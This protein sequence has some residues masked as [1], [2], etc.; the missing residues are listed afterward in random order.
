MIPIKLSLKNFMCYREAELNLEGIHLACLNGDNG[1]G[2]SSLLDAI[3]WSLWGKSRASDDEIITQQEVEMAVHL[4]FSMGEQTY[5]VS[6]LRSKKG[7]GKTELNFSIYNGSSWTRISED[8]VRATQTKI[9]KTLGMSYETF[10]NS[11]FLLQGHA[12]EFTVRT[13]TERK[14]VLAEILGLGYYDELEQRAKEFAKDAE[15][16]RRDLAHQLENLIAI[17]QQRPLFEL[18]FKEAENELSSHIEKLKIAED[19]KSRLDITKGALEAKEQRKRDLENRLKII[20]KDVA[21][22]N[23]KRTEAERAKQSCEVIIQN[24]VETEK[25]Y[26]QFEKIKSEDEILQ[27]KASRHLELS[28]LQVRLSGA[29][30]NEKR[31]LQMK[32]NAKQES[33]KEQEKLAFEV[34]TIRHELEKAQREVEKANEAASNLEQYQKQQN[35]LN[36][37]QG[38]FAGEIKRLNDEMKRVKAKADQLPAAGNPCERCGALMTEEARECT[39]Q[40]YRNE[41]AELLQQQKQIKLEKETIET[42]LAKLVD[43]IAAVEPLAKTRVT[44]EKRVASV[45]VKLQNAEQA[46]Q[47]IAELQAQIDEFNRQ[48]ENKEYAQVEQQKLAQVEAELVVLNYDDKYHQKIQVQRDELKHF[49]MEYNQRLVPTLDRLPL[50][51]EQL[52]DFDY[53]LNQYQTEKS[54]KTNNLGELEAELSGLEELRRK[55]SRVT[56]EVSDIRKLRDSAQQRKAKAEFNLEE[57]DAAASEREKVQKLAEQANL[58]K[59]LYDD[60]AGAFGKKGIQALVIESVLPELEAE[61]NQLLG[62]MTAGRMSVRFDTQR[63]TRRGDSTIETLDLHISDEVGMRPYELFS[64]GEAF[65]VNFAVR[66]ALSK[67]LAR[68]NGAQLRTLFIDEGFGTQDDKGRERLVEAIHSIENQFDRILVITHIPEL[69]DAFPVRID[70]EKTPNGSRVSIN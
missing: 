38:T 5:K 63:D 9:I 48:L 28:R 33:Q 17:V 26:A 44:T 35:E 62:D 20:E 23:R 54:E 14:K 67:L 50:L 66:I 59:S 18:Q 43:L 64:G 47:K 56:Q 13:P 36:V 52:E 12:D 46:E 10:I 29:I 4:E 60:L 3:T 57:C 40:Q 32:R 37:K 11:A 31:G 15:T 42:E 49:D 8:S 2:K 68:R 19:E 41:Y 24:R 7:S 30:D 58:E 55:L 69:K 70:V 65:R 53:R 22:I 21:D 51:V 45:E 34:K 6:R 39:L 25:G 61:A 1:A 16:N 27:K